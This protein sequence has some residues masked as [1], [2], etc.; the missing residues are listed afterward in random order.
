MKDEDRTN[1]REI[2]GEDETQAG[3]KPRGRGGT[4]E[5]MTEFIFLNVSTRE[6]TLMTGEGPIY[7]YMWL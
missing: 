3:G 2:V 7:C 5:R 6:S 1:F 4:T